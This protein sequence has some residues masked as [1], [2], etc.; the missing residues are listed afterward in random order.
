MSHRRT[1]TAVAFAA[2]LIALA[3]H[4]LGVND[5]MVKPVQNPTP[6]APSAPAPVPT[7]VNPAAIP[8]PAPGAPAVAPGTPI[9]T[10]PTAALPNALELEFETFNWGDIPD[11]AQVAKKVSFKNTTD[12]TITI[13]ASATCGCTVAGLEK[14]VYAPGES[15]SIEAKFNPTGRR[16]PQQKEVIITVTDPQGVY[17]QQRVALT[18][19]VK[20]LVWMEPQKI[21]E[22]EVN[23]KD[24]KTATF[25]IFGRKPD[26]NITK[27]ESASEFVK[28]TIGKPNTIEQNGEQVV[29]VPIEM[30]IG[31]GA[32]LGTLQ[33]QVTVTTNDDKAPT[34][35]MFVG[36]DV[37]GEIKATPPQAIIRTQTT[38]TP[39]KTEVRVDTRTGKAFK[40]TGVEVEGRSDMKLVPDVSAGEGGKWYMITLSGVTPAEPS[41]VQGAIIVTADTNDGETIRIPFTASVVRAAAPVAPAPSGQ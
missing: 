23:H 14:N 40:I 17:A 12:R 35:T 3:G 25:K 18:S 37:V 1:P 33:T 36:G 22:P 21:F 5:P 30:V 32:P 15:G 41:F 4:A 20:P 13:A 10:Q 24:G 26:F 6:A 29:E 28:A 2:G 39:F 8:T 16:G 34:Q 19:N 9:P 7:P 27:A 11:T 31:K 38:N